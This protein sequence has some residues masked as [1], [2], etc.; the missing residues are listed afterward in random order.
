MSVWER[1][2]GFHSCDY[3]YLL[4]YSLHYESKHSF[5][6]ITCFL[7]NMCKPNSLLLSHSSRQLSFPLC[8]VLWITRSSSHWLQLIDPKILKSMKWL[9]AWRLFFFFFQTGLPDDLEKCHFLVNL[10]LVSLQ[11]Y[12]LLGFLVRGIS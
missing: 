8:Y 6:F 7:Q 9:E 11:L 10:L 5:I 4:L 1:E 3:F 2:S 12:H